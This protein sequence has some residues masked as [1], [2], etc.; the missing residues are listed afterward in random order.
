MKTIKEVLW[1]L[2]ASIIL[3][4]LTMLILKSG[5]IAWSVDGGEI[6]S[7]KEFIIYSVVACINICIAIIIGG[8]SSALD[9]FING[10][11]R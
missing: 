1:L 8:I 4:G 5:G 7:I 2:L 3:G 10:V 11:E 6:S 9:R